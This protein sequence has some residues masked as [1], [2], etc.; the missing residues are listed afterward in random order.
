MGR[1]LRL[2]C[3]LLFT[4]L[5]PLRFVSMAIASLLL[6]NGAL[7][8]VGTFLTGRYSPGPVTSVLCA[9]P[10]AIYTWIT[11]PAKWHLGALQ[12]ILAILLGVLW[13][14]IPL[15]FMVRR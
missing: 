12:V 14:L 11:I 3:R 13:Q 7:H 4:H 9:F 15:V 1:L 10:T 6:A 5:K 2:S 8:I